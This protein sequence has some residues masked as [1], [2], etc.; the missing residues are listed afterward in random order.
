MSKFSTLADSLVKFGDL[1]SC[2]QAAT[3]L[4]NV[5]AAAAEPACY[6]VEFRD[7]RIPI[8]GKGA[9]LDLARRTGGTVKPLGVIA[10]E[11]VH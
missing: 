10:S 4:L 7:K 9:A 3:I 11:V 8:M 5:E 1:A 6:L 2:N